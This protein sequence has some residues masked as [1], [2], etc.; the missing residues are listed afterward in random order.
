MFNRVPHP[1][2]VQDSGSI[3]LHIHNV[4]TRGGAQLHAAS[5]VFLA[6]RLPSACWIGGWVGQNV[7]TAY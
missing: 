3:A 7:V 1:E 4:S 5:S 2:G 6:K